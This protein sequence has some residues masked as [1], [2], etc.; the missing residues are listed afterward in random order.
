MTE[1][2]QKKATFIFCSNNKNKIFEIQKKLSQFGIDIISQKEA[3]YDIEVEETGKTFQ[4]NSLIKAESIYKLSKKPVIADDSGLCID[5]LNGEPGI[6]S[7]RFAGDN[8]SDKDRHNKVLKLLEG[9]EDK[10][11]TCRYTCCVCYIDS[12]GDKHF[13]EDYLEGKIALDG[14]KGNN[15]FGYDP[16]VVLNDGRHVA[17][18][19]PEEKNKISHRGKAINKL[20]EY[21]KENGF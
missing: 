7:H 2:T 4:E 14:P 20:V 15:G 3:G 6:H 21:I 11:R 10:K 19:S 8:A 17:E 5:Y 9:V 12:N 13:F 18:L 1:N 16:I